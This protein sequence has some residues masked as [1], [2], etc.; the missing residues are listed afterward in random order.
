MKFINC[1]DDISEVNKKFLDLNRDNKRQ[2]IIFLLEFKGVEYMQIE[3][4]KTWM[5]MNKS[6]SVKRIG[7]ECIFSRIKLNINRF[8]ENM[9]AIMLIKLNIEEWIIINNYIVYLYRVYN[10]NFPR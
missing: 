3:I 6:G 7:K 9:D 1:L 8:V 10:Y 5:Y 4:M 2:G